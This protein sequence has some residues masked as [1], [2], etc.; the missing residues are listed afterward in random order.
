[1]RIGNLYRHMYIDTN[2]HIAYRCVDL[3]LCLFALATCLR[4]EIV[5]QVC[6][7]LK[8]RRNWHCLDRCCVT[9]HFISFRFNS[10]AAAIPNLL[11]DFRYFQ[12]HSEYEIL[13]VAEGKRSNT[14]TYK[15]IKTQRFK[16]VCVSEIVWYVF[17]S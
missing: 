1:M 3:Y 6:C 14:H 5:N 13:Q 4:A 2:E 10:F 16:L 17:C 7:I 8:S 11:H 15:Y 9:F 12:F